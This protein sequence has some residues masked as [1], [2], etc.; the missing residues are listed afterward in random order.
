MRLVNFSALQLPT[1]ATL[2]PPRPTTHRTSHLDTQLQS[3]SDHCCLAGIASRET[4]EP[5]LGF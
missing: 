4:D 2:V 5:A 3:K 1:L